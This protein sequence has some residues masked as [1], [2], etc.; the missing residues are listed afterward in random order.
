MAS[1]YYKLTYLLP[2]V[3]ALGLFLMMTLTNPLTAGPAGMLVVFFLAYVFCASVLFIVLHWG[4]SFVTGTMSRS[5]RFNVR[6]WRVGVKKAYYT[7]SIVAFAPVLLLAMQSVGQLQVRDIVLM[8]AFV[9]IA[10]FYVLK[11]T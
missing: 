6:E 10:I 4:V 8:I 7:A 11:R 3:S 5:Q 9:A 2:L 1:H